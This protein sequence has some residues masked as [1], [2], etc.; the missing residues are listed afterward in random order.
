MRVQL[1]DL[2]VSRGSIPKLNNFTAAIFVDGAEENPTISSFVRPVREEVVAKV[3]VPIKKGFLD[4]CNR[5]EIPLC[6]FCL[7]TG[8]QL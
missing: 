5:C 8:Q 1:I 3:K 2:G 7:L 4:K 6:R